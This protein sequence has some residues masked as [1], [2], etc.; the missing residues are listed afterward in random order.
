MLDIDHGTYPFVTSS[1]PLSGA[2]CVG[3]GRRAEGDRR[4]MGRL[5]GLHH[6]RGRRAVPER[7]ARRDRRDDP[8][9]GRR[10]RHD[11][12]PPAPHRLARSRGAALR[13]PPEHAHGA[14][15]HQA[16]RA[17]G[18]RPRS[19]CARATGARRA[20]SSTTSPTT[21]R[22]C[23]T[24]PPSSPSC[25]AGRR[26]S[27]SAARCRTCPTARASICSSSPSTPACPVTL[28][29]RGP[30]SRAGGVDGGRARVDPVPGQQR[31]GRR[32]ESLARREGIGEPAGS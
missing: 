18:L 32:I 14:R 29:R 23:T 28:D 10:V 12:R 7:A 24:P 5:Q 17:L 4:G 22:C 16:R 20:R 19:A 26:T 3:S 11:H 2:A 1:N 9:A 27:A 13:G 6:A 21:R 8:Q 30:G 15:A 31:A 25:A